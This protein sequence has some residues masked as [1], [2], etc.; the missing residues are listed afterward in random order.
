MFF[1]IVGRGDDEVFVHQYGAYRDFPFS[2][3]FFCFFQGKE[4]IFSVCHISSFLKRM[5]FSKII[6]INVE[7]NGKAG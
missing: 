7:I 2:P 6:I 4:H 5:F 1:F 3:C